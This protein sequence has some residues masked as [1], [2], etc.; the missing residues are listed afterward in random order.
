MSK[1]KI[2]A[3]ATAVVGIVGVAYTISF[4]GSEAALV[5]RFPDIDSELVVK[6]HRKMY[7]A[8]LRGEFSNTST[9]DATM[10][11]IFLATVNELKK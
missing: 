2:T 3:I 8:A 1:T 6:A 9:D 4:L 10:D 7:F 5:E 11:E